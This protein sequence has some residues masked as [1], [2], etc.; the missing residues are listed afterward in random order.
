MS[1]A[2]DIFPLP[3]F[4]DAFESTVDFDVNNPN[5]ITIE[6]NIKDNEEILAQ[7]RLD[8]VKTFMELYQIASDGFFNTMNRH[9]FSL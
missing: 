4:K 3:R 9:N 8:F 2:E 6:K 7:Y 5:R 1:P